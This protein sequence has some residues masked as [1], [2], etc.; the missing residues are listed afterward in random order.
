MPDARRILWAPLDSRLGARPRR[1]RAA[2]PLRPARCRARKP[3][4]FSPRLRPATPTPRA[5]RALNSV[6]ACSWKR[7]IIAVS[8]RFSGER[9]ARSAVPALGSAALSV[10]PVV[11][12][13]LLCYEPRTPP[14]GV[15]ATTP[16]SR[17]AA[18]SGAL[19][20]GTSVSGTAC[21]AEG[22][23]VERLRWAEVRPR[24]RVHDEPLKI[25][26]FWVARGAKSK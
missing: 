26:N 16:A 25:R 22:L 19:Q 5:L 2:A 4:G 13:L 18:R 17:R 20:G 1:L 9:V 24:A 12:W 7:A 11:P 6:S 21:P 15:H 8:R 3:E 14:G 23:R 10:R